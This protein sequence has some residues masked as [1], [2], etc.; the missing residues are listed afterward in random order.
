MTH[1]ARPPLSEAQEDYLKQILL[2][3][4]GE[5]LEET[6]SVSTQA[7]ADQMEIKPASVTG[8]LKKLAELGLVEYEAYK[9]VRL[10]EAGYKVALEVLRHHR[11]LEAYLHQALGYGWEEVHAEAERLEHHISEAFEAR[12]AEWLGH[13]SH[14]PHGDPIPS[15]ELTLPQDAPTQRLTA[16]AVGQHGLVARVLTQDHDSLN[17]LAHLHLRPGAWVGVLEHAP[18]GL[19]IEVRREHL[20]ERFLLPSSLAQIVWV[21]PQ[22]DRHR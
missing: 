1:P 17:L 8:M 3:G 10:T 2:L 11:L 16:L 18:E 19:R 14:D 7:L 5:K 9:G 21:V 6:H 22:E 13:P 20:E 12:I 4:G 15:V